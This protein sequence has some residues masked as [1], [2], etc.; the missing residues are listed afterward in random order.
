MGHLIRVPINRSENYFIK[1]FSFLLNFFNINP[2][3]R[4][5]PTISVIRTIIDLESP[6]TTKFWKPIS[7]ANRRPSRQASISPMKG[8]ETKL[9]HTI[10]L[11]KTWP[12]A[13]LTTKPEEDCWLWA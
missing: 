1:H 8:S 7:V 6:S 13:F 2:D 11:P 10:P 4:S 9:F 5:I 12:W 3:C